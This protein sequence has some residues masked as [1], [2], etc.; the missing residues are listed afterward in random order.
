MLLPKHNTV[1]LIPEISEY[2][3]TFNQSRAG[4]RRCTLKSLITNCDIG[5]LPS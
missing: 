1:I 3:Y 5:A 4:S 2:Q